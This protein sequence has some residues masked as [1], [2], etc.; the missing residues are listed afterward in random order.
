MGVDEPRGIAAF[1]HPDHISLR[2]RWVN[3][4]KYDVSCELRPPDMG[5]WLC[6][7]LHVQRHGKR[8]LR[9]PEYVKMNICLG[10]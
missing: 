8:K 7:W 5:T 6:K 10:A 9:E 4:G 3:Q 1:Y 2:L